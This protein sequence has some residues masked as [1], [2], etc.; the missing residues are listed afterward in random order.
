VPRGSVPGSGGG[1][2]VVRGGGYY[3][4]YYDPWW[5]GPG[6]VGDY[7]GYY[8]PWY[9][10]YPSYGSY[11]QSTSSYRDDGKLRLKIKPR[12]AEVY[13]DGYFA[14]TVDDFDGVFQR[15]HLETGAHQITVQAPGYE[16]LTFGVRITPENT[17]T[18]EGELKKTP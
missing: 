1:V 7:G 11:S 18:Y 14:G 5:Y 9:G 13:V 10:G 2:I 6:Y 4:G 12:Q 15:L 3:G 16:P 17:T 8:D